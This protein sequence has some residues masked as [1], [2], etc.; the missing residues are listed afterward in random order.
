MEWS[1]ICKSGERDEMSLRDALIN[2]PNFS[3]LDID[4][5]ETAA[6]EEPFFKLDIFSCSRDQTSN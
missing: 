1:V 6:D 5:D 3:T 4:F 2:K